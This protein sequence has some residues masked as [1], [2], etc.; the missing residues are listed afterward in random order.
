MPEQRWTPPMTSKDFFSRH[1][2]YIRRYAAAR[3]LSPELCEHFERDAI[4]Y[5]T[6]TPGTLSVYPERY[7]NSLSRRMAIIG[8]DFTP[9]HFFM[10]VQGSLQ[11]RWLTFVREAL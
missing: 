9:A 11:L 4:A 8:P 3:N 7:Q 5:L 1:P 10:W 2:D 6:S